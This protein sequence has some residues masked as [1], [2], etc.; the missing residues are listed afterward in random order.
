MNL[1]KEL[2]MI[3]IN[4]E[5]GDLRADMTQSLIMKR[6]Y[7]EGEQEPAILRVGLLAA[8]LQYVLVALEGISDEVSARAVQ[9][10]GERPRPIRRPTGV[11]DHLRQLDD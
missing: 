1:A 2:V 4:H 11:D 6:I 3:T 5:F 7:G 10:T 9:G 8:T